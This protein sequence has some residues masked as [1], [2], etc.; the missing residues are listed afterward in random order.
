MTNDNYTCNENHSTVRSGTL[1]FSNWHALPSTA[2]GTAL[3][4]V[5]AVIVPS[6]VGGGYDTDAAPPDITAPSWPV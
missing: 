1:L 3:V 4:A 2:N 5:F 6:T